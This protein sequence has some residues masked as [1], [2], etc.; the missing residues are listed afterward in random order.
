[1][2]EEAPV[3]IFQSEYELSNLYRIVKSIN[4]TKIVEIGS[5][6]G[7]TLWHWMR[8]CK[9]GSTFVA[10]DMMVAKEDNRY[11]LQQ[12]CHNR[13]WYEW[14]NAKQ[15]NLQVIEGSSQ[16]P[17]V[18]ETIYEKYKPVDFLFIDGDHTYGGVKRDFQ[19]YLD[20]VRPGG[21]MAFHDIAIPEEDSIVWGGVSR[22]WAEIKDS[23]KYVIEE[24]IEK[25]RW[26]GIGVL[27]VPNRV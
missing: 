14:A 3:E 25:P 27:Y 26:W 8:L 18:I 11:K 23:K 4:P 24:F 1:M 5:L 13:L 20:L 9:P 22:L 12:Y 10:V 19:N 15:H 21:V 2:I 7:G 6:F 17:K 16:D